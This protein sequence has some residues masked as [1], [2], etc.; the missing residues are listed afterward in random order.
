MTETSAY[1]VSFDWLQ[2]NLGKPGL[3]I[4]DASWYLPT[5]NRDPRAEYAAGH[6]PGAINIPID[7]LRARMSELPRDRAL[8]VYCQ[9]GQR[10][11]LATR[12]LLQNRFEARNIG[13][14]YKTYKLFFPHA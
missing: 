9:V 5:H 10:G 2:S 6:I 7:E 12:I 8:A 11:Y 1:V 14:G 4:V 13:G 3:S